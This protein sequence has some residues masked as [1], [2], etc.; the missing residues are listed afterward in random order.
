M[1]AGHAFRCSACGKPHSWRAE[2]AV[3]EATLT[4]AALRNA[5]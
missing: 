5:A 3:V 4:L 2:E 1:G